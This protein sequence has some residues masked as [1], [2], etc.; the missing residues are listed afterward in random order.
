VIRA[1][2][3]APLLAVGA[4]SLIWQVGSA[5]SLLE[6]LR[7]NELGLGLVLMSWLLLVGLGS[8]LGAWVGSRASAP[9]LGC[10]LLLLVPA[11]LL[12]SLAVQSHAALA[13]PGQLSPVG[14]AT[15]LAMLSLAPACLLLGAA[16]ALAARA[17]DGCTPDHWAALVFALESLGTV[18]AGLV[19]HFLLAGGSLRSAGLV[20]GGVSWVAALPSLGALRGRGRWAAVSAALVGALALLYLVPDLPLPGA[21]RLERRIPGYRLLVHRNSPHA[22]LAVLGRGDQLLFTASGQLVFSN[23]DDERLELETHLALLAHPSPERVLLLGGGLGGGVTE[24]LKHRPERVDVVE[25]DPLLVDLARRYAPEL[26]RGLDDPRVRL[27]LGD[28]R[29]WLRRSPAASYDAILVGLPGPSSAL[30]NRFYTEEFL[31]AAGRALRPGGLVRVALEG[32]E[33]YLSPTAALTHRSVR[34]AMQAAGLHPVV[35][36]GTT[37]LFL[38]GV[39]AQPRLEARELLGRLEARHLR[40][41]FFGRAEVMDATLPFKRE[42]YEQ[43]AGDQHGLHAGS[44]RDLHP[45]AYFQATVL[46]L[47]LGSPALG[48]AAL[49]LGEEVWR[50]PWLAPLAGL[51]IGLLGAAL[52]RRR[53]AAGLALLAAGLTGLALELEVLLACQ[54]ARGVVYRELGILMASFMLGVT[55]GALA[56]RRLLA[57]I[58]RYALTVALG[59][60]GVSALVTLAVIP[61]G[62]AHPDAALWLLLLVLLVCGAS[63]G[64]CYPPAAAILAVRHGAAASSRAYAWD[65]LGAALG[66]LFAGGLALPVLGLAGTSAFCAALC[67]GGAAGLRRGVG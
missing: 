21:T 14:R 48:G 11:G 25:L 60:C 8:V 33:G 47:A 46:W 13:D 5:R 51:L 30:T 1:V 20:A 54:L 45:T 3:G 64:A 59:A 52:R 16:F 39:D 10:A 2:R 4:T 37:T 18:A 57:A 56:G 66:S 9:T 27:I 63:V 22:A 61:L 15:A 42:I 40:T 28:G 55:L 31:R 24:V 32:G 67:L 7:G 43:A 29:Q 12:V 41:R 62:L 44:N 58:P 50:R 23:Q 26:T 36:P 19:F 53:P 6:G 35:L 49:R 65:L 38:C 34:L 17:P